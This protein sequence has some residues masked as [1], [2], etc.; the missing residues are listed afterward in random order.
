M[1]S[2]A[3]FCYDCLSRVKSLIGDRLGRNTLIESYTS[4]QECPDDDWK[5]IC[6]NYMEDHARL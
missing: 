2:Q 4:L 3:S 1:G 6:V 5:T